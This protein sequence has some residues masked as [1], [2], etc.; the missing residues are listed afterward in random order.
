MLII[1]TRSGYRSM[2]S[3]DKVPGSSIRGSD[4]LE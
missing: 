1:Y 2:E 4:A 3:F